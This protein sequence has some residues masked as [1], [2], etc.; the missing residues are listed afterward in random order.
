MKIWR[1]LRA[2]IWPSLPPLTP[3]QKLDL[4]LHSHPKCC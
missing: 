2:R 4:M 3:E 1:S